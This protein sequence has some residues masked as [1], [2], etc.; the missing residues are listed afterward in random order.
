MLG[1]RLVLVLPCTGPK[2]TRKFSDS[3]TPWKKTPLKKTKKKKIS[4]VYRYAFMLP[5]NNNITAP[6]FVIA[7]QE[8]YNAALTEVTAVRIWK[9]V[10]CTYTLT[11]TYFLHTPQSRPVI[12]LKTCKSGMCS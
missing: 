4:R 8:L 3:A 1:D 9:F 11:L 5:T 2:I 7:Y 12:Q 6:M 10:S